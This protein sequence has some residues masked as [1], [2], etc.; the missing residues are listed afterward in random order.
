VRLSDC[1]TGPWTFSVDG[2]AVNS[3]SACPFAMP[4]D[5]QLYDTRTL[6]NGAHSVRAVGSS[7]VTATFI[8]NNG[9]APPQGT[10]TATLGWNP[11][12][13]NV[14]GSIP[15]DLAGFRILYG[16]SPTALVQTIDIANPGVA[17]YV[18]QNLTGGPWYF[19]VRGYSSTGA[20]SVNSNVVL[21]TIQ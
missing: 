16:S 9:G 15:I 2:T 3:Q 19:T 5:D 4:E 18:V 12:T 10:G 11:P 13:T 17:T 8:V 1:S 21:K 14:D 7:T 20:E 6:S